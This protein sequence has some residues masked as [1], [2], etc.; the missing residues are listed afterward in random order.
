MRHEESFSSANEC[1][2]NSLPN[3]SIR[4]HF[5][6]R[7][8][9]LFASQL[10]TCRNIGW[11]TEAKCLRSNNRIVYGSFTLGATYALQVPK[12]PKEQLGI[13]ETGER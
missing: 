13:Y 1:G 9:N 4:W 7:Y 10:M 5:E 12:I 11:I 3:K 8:S 2:S 6:V